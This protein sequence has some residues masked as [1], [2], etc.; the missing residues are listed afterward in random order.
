MHST[1][2]QLVF[3]QNK[4]NEIIN[5]KQL[6][7]KPKII[8]V[9]KTFPI[10]NIIPLLEYGHIH[11][12]ENKIQEAEEKWTDIRN[13]Y[14]NFQL[15]M[16]GK[17]QTNKVKKAVKLFDY[18]HS[19]DNERLALKIFQYQK[20]L[21][22]EVKLF[23]QI[24]L[25]AEREKSGLAINNLNRT[26]GTFYTVEDLVDR[27][28]LRAIRSKYDN[29]PLGLNSADREEFLRTGTTQKLKDKLELQKNYQTIQKE[30][31]SE[32]LKKQKELL[33]KRKDFIKEQKKNNITQSQAPAS[34]TL[35]KLDNTMM[36]SMTAGS[37][38][39]IDPTTLLTSNETALL[40]PSEQAYY[41]N[42]RKA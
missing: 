18:I 39:D 14:K 10:K 8:V 33:Q 11:Y 28:A 3:V 13:N 21:N 15:H 41:I 37:A 25:A 32:D 17:L 24:N 16:I 29:I 27:D 35:P 36:A 1:L 34:M 2:K 22:K 42:K 26:L 19:L 7:T 23:I 38:G 40:S 4:I 5:T 20:E 9:T 6:K 30:Q 12:G 31:F